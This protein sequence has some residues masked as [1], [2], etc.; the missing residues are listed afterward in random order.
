MKFFKLCVATLMWAMFFGVSA[1]SEFSTDSTPVLYG[2]ALEAA[3]TGVTFRSGVHVY[4]HPETQ[5]NTTLLEQ[6]DGYA[7]LFT[8]PYGNTWTM[9]T[10]HALSDQDFAEAGTFMAGMTQSG[11]TFYYGKVLNWEINA[12]CV[13]YL[14]AGG[15]EFVMIRRFQDQGA[16]PTAAGYAEW[17]PLADVQF[18]TQV[19]P[20]WAYG[21]NN[22]PD[23]IEHGSFNHVPVYGNDPYGHPCGDFHTLSDCSAYSGITLT[24]T[25][26]DSG[27]FVN[28]YLRVVYDHTTLWAGPAKY[29]YGSSRTYG[30][31]KHPNCGSVRP[32]VGDA[33]VSEGGP[34]GHAAIVRAVSDHSV[35]VIQ[36]NWFESPADNSSTLRMRTSGNSYCVADFGDGYPVSGWLRK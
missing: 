32:R 24:G 14:A 3:D 21:V 22:S 18:A 15:G 23:N 26:W 13:V 11:A 35:T 17:L 34:A 1:C 16:C 29:L 30:L 12:E 33:L 31:N 6:R 9:S 19:S 7:T 36:Q 27:E 10:A 4:P 28:R 8:D 25:K 20:L 5:V 2:D